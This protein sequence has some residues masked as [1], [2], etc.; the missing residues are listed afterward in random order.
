MAE[1]GQ[2]GFPGLEAEA[3]LGSDVYADLQIKPLDRGLMRDKEAQGT[4][5]RVVRTELTKASGAD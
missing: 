5:E 4:P 1:D 3:G 2:G